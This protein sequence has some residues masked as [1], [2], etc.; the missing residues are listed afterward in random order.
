MGGLSSPALPA[1]VELVSHQAVGLLVQLIRPLAVLSDLA[2][3]RFP[4][5][6]QCDTVQLGPRFL[7]TAG[8]D[9]N[10]SPSMIHQLFADL[11]CVGNDHLCGCRRRGGADVGSEIGQGEVGLVSHAADHRDVRGGPDRLLG[12]EKTG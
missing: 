11:G 3:R 4:G 10:R 12:T 6:I 1:Q 9:P 5:E 8:Y 2:Q 7:Q